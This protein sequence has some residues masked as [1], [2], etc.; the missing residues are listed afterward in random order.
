VK[1]I[2]ISSKIKMKNSPAAAAEKIAKRNRY[3]N[4]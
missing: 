1:I 4:K 2:I 3:K